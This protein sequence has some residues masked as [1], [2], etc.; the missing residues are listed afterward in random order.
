MRK[1]RM[2][3]VKDTNVNVYM[4]INEKK[5]YMEYMLNLEYRNMAYGVRE[6]LRRVFSY[7]V[8]VE[9]VFDRKWKEELPPAL[10][11]DNTIN[12]SDYNIPTVLCIPIS[13]M[14]LDHLWILAKRNGYK[15]VTSMILSILREKTGYKPL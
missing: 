11:F 5:F 3:V 13:H 15:N 9:G 4:T 6:V 2:L 10:E 14:E 7:D 8:A 1:R 12:H